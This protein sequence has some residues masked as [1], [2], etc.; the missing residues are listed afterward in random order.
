MFKL[1]RKSM[2]GQSTA[3]YAIML[4]LVIAAVVA[5]QI[6][7]Q[8]TIKGKV[9][10]ASNYLSVAGNSLFNQATTQYEPYYLNTDYTTETDSDL[11]VSMTN[12][13]MGGVRSDGKTE[14]TRTGTQQYTYNQ[15]MF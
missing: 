1:I 2:K 13:V 10:D 8:R 5:M 9:F 12:A 3:E 7:V 15:D 6:Y 11:T 4:G 14:T